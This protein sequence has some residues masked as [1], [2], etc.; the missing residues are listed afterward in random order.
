M[1]IDPGEAVSKANGRAGPGDWVDRVRLTYEEIHTRLWQS[2]VGWSGST[3]VAD[4]ATAD[5][6]RRGM[7]R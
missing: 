3:D 6:E 4:E 7:D 5:Q 1:T 2:L